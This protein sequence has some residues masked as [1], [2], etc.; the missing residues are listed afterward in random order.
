M[1][2]ILVVVLLLLFVGGPGYAWRRDGWTFGGTDIVGVLLFVVLLV[3]L[4][5]LLGAV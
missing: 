1:V 4:L 5:R 2:L 3:A